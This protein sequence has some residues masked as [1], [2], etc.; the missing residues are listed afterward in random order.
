[1]QT[2]DFE[3]ERQKADE[4]LARLLGELVVEPID[5]QLEEQIRD[6]LFSFGEELD[7]KLKKQLASVA[8]NRDL[9]RCFLEIG[10]NLEGLERK[11]QHQGTALDERLGSFEQEQTG[12]IESMQALVR[13]LAVDQQAD[14]SSLREQ[15]QQHD[16]ALG[17]RLSSLE[18]EQA[19]RI[20]AMQTLVR[21]LTVDQQANHVAV[22]LLL[23]Q[24]GEQL[25]TTSRAVADRQKQE[26][27]A[28]AAQFK[29]QISEQQ[30]QLYRSHS[31][32]SEMLK[33]VQPVPDVLADFHRHVVGDHQK[34]LEILLQ[35]QEVLEIQKSEIN[36]IRKKM[37]RF[38][39]LSVGLGCAIA[40]ALYAPLASSLLGT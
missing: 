15:L 19:Q 17:K 3:V 39:W 30:E 27:Q 32:L 21:Q 12:R 1:M 7:S 13:Q 20:D 9:E 33:C 14:T 2:L 6:E 24:L 10:K 28:L 35:Q 25:D 23:S 34:F 38:A 31:D 8:K 18:Q 36:N 26:V 40:F 16:V 29:Q 4:E 37:M 22:D 11:L 5:R